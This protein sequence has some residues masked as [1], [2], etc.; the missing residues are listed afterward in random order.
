MTQRLASTSPRLSAAIKFGELLSRTMAEREV[1]QGI[2]RT[3]AGVS[4]SSV[5]EFRNGRNLPTLEVALRIAEAL[6][7]PRLAE[8]VRKARTLECTRCGRPYVNERGFP[9][10]YCSAACRTL[11]QPVGRKRRTDAESAVMILRGEMLRIGAVRKQQIGRAL[12]LLD[13]FHAPEKEALA[14]VDAYQD[15]IAGMCA[16]CEP[17]GLCRTAECPLRGVSPLP[18]ISNDVDVESARKPL[19]RWGR[20]E[21]RAA[22]SQAMRERHAADPEW[23]RRSGERMR[24]VW[25]ELGPAERSRRM[26]EARRRGIEARKVAAQ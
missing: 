2:V 11:G 18:L 20:P 4:R 15:A 12:T 17:D 13:D 14:A 6:N 21:L 16:A 26:S 3:A 8:I 7:E 23:R 19:G 1:G 25:A 5:V 22:H 9:K 24:E 10:R